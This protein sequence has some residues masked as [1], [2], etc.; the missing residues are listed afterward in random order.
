MRIDECGEDEKMMLEKIKDV[1]REYCFQE[2]KLQALVSQSMSSVV[3]Y[4]MVGG[5]RHQS[6]A[7]AEDGLID[8]LK[9]ESFE[10]QIV[11]IIRGD[12]AYNPEKMNIVEF[13]DP[14]E[15]KLT[16]DDRNCRICKIRKAW[17]ASN[18]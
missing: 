18:A 13:R 11:S 8:P 15:F 3:F 7:M 6:N 14:A 4:A 12:K 1:I 10:K 9:L 5:Q 17:E 2:V 16:Y